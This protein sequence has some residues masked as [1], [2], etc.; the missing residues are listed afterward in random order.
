MERL[1]KRQQGVTLLEI[2]L[3]L[4]IAA[5]IVT[6]SIRYYRSAATAQQASMMVTAA[7]A[8][9]AEME[10][11]AAG[12]ATYTCVPAAILSKLTPLVVS[13]TAATATSYTATIQSVNNDACLRAMQQLGSGTKYITMTCNGTGRLQYTYNNAL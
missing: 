6:M 12:R 10:S 4:A 3:V 8:V 9:T 1:I 7:Q 11:F 5:I 2:L 13:C